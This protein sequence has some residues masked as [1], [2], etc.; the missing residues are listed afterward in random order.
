MASCSIKLGTKKSETEE[1][2]GS[3]VVSFIRSEG[4]VFGIGISAEREGLREKT[5]RN[6]KDME[7]TSN[8][9]KKKKNDISPAQE[10]KRMVMSSN[11]MSQPVFHFDRKHQQPPILDTFIN[12]APIL[13]D[14][15]KKN[16]LI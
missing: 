10:F 15:G 11:L 12:F 16:L 1:E 6:P 8:P 2:S 7:F 9:R 13:S 3:P 4:S 5:K 14:C